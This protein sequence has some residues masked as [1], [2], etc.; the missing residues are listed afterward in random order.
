VQQG[1]G[2]DHYLAEQREEDRAARLQHRMLG[3]TQYLFVDRLDHEML[4]QPRGIERVEVLA[5]AWLERHDLD[6]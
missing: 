3:I 2:T 6:L 4:P 5:Q 1:A